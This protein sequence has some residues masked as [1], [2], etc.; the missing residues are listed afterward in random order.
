MTKL[1]TPSGFID[2]AVAFDADRI[3][4]VVADSSTKAELHV[5]VLSTKAEQVVDIA[6]VSLHPLSITLVAQ[7][8][9]VVGETDGGKQIAAMVDLVDRGK[10]KPAGTILYKV[11][12][13]THITLLEKQGRIAVHRVTLLSTSTK[14][15][16]EILAI[17]SGKRIGAVRT[18]E[19][20][21]GDVEKQLDFRV[22]HWSEGWTKA[23]GIKGGDW[24]KKENQRSPDTEATYDMVNAKLVDRKKIDDLFEQRKRYQ[25][26]ADANGKLDFVRVGWDNKSLQ[27]WRGGK[28]NKL[29]LEQALPT[30][31]IKSLQGVVTPDAVWVAAKVDPVNADAVARKKADAEYLD[32]FRAQPDGKA[33][34]KVRVL[35]AGLRHR[36]GVMGADRFY[37]LERNQSME[38]GGKSLTVYRLQ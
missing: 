27:A 30:Y 32:I 38:R 14:H 5:V 31:D 36:F 37:L 34:R 1:T 13:A 2:D 24:D 3:A 28:L 19:L 15:E 26:L 35:A 18:I 16:I 7:R 23:H 12:A 6:P 9:F 8:A 33:N 25:A 21:V 11:P 4:Y 17:D 22:N 29:E 20:G 10:Q